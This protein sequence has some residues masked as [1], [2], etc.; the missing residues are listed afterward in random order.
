[1]GEMRILIDLPQNDVVEIETAAKA[2]HRTRKD[3]LEWIIID[4]LR[5]E[6][7]KSA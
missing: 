3:Q 1:M 5:K 4:W 7:K 2:A 6:A